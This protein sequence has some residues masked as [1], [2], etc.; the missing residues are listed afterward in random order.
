MGDG[1]VVSDQKENS[2]LNPA[3]E[4]IMESGHWI[5]LKSDGLIL[6]VCLARH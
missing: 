6:M 2:Y 1:L 3:S 5:F 4:K